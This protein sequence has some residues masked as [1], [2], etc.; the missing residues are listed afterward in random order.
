MPEKLWV[1]AYPGAFADELNGSE[2]LPDEETV[3]VEGSR[4]RLRFVS[5]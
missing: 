2:A 5:K 3:M 1:W 4:I